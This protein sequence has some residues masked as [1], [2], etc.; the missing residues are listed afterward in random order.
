VIA[1]AAGTTRLVASKRPPSP[2]SSTATST[3]ASRNRS[4]ATAVVASKKV[5][6]VSSAP[7]ARADAM[8][9]STRL[10]A[11]RIRSGST[12][13]PS[14]ANRSSRRIR[15]GEV[16]RPVRLP[17]ARRPASTMAATEPLPL[18][19]ATSTELHASCG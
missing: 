18:V 17:E 11:D 9:R 15:C 16:Y 4:K 19:P 7:R 5:G 1:P 8:A 3:P 12:G 13:R 6:S 10:A 2:T 14:M